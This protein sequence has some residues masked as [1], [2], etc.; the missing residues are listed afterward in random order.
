MGSTTRAGSSGSPIAAPSSSQACSTTCGL[1]TG[2]RSRYSLRAIRS[3]GSSGPASVRAPARRPTTAD[4]SEPCRST[5]RSKF[6]SRRTSLSRPISFKRSRR[7]AGAW[8]TSSRDAVPAVN[9]RWLARLADTLRKVF[10]VPR[11]LQQVGPARFNGPA[12]KGFGMTGAQ[13]R[14]GGK[15]VQN[16][17]HRADSHDEHTQEGFTRSAPPAAAARRA[18]RE[19][20]SSGGRYAASPRA[21]RTFSQLRSQLHRIL[22]RGH[23]SDSL[24][25]DTIRPPATRP[26]VCTCD[27]RE[28]GS[29][30]ASSTPRLR[31]IEKNPADG[32]YRRKRRPASKVASCPDDQASANGPDRGL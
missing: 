5:T 23:K 17:A 15:G 4:F 26:R 11:H 3:R 8:P 24:Q 21:F 27:G 12:D 2:I 31:S 22:L 1:E 7:R 25:D 20:R 10:F 14:H 30:R 19:T 13:G 32:R 29:R 16:I 18:D 28:T 6:S 9:Q